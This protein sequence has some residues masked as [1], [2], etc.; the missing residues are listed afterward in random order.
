MTPHHIT[1]GRR[2]QYTRQQRAILSYRRRRFQALQS[3]RISNFHLL[4][5]DSLP[6]PLFCVPTTLEDGG[7]V[8]HPRSSMGG[9]GSWWWCG[10]ARGTPRRGY[11]KGGRRSCKTAA[12]E[13]RQRQ[14]QRKCRDGGKQRGAATSSE[15]EVCTFRSPPRH[16]NDADGDCSCSPEYIRRA[17]ASSSSPTSIPLY[18]SSLAAYPS[19]STPVFRMTHGRDMK[20]SA[21]VIARAFTV[22]VSTLSM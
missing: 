7:F 8:L 5:A 3:R 2:L 6:R 19:P 10:S 15:V 17:C 20:L 9:G 1:R 16:L 22:R 12:G 18:R 21:P 11:V 13:T 4:T 14:R